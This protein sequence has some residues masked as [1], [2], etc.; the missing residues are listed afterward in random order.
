ME[1][2]II[3]VSLGPAPYLRSSAADIV[4]R[5]PECLEERT[6]N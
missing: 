2:A 1:R 4:V 3:P 6:W 5:N